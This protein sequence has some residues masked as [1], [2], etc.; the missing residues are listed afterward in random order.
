MRIDIITLFPE[1]F[2]GP[3]ALSIIGRAR[4]RSLVDIG[5]VNPRDFVKDRHRTVDDRPYGG[6]KGM[7]LMAEP[8]YQAIRSVRRKDTKV[9]YLSPKGQTFTQKAARDLSRQKHLALLCGHYEGID[10]RILKYVDMEL[11]IGDYVLTGGEIPAMA[12]TDAVVR[13][14]PDV[15]PEGAV[16][17]ES[18]SRYGLEHPQYTRPRLW[19]G[20]RVPAALVAGD[21]A[22][23]ENWRQAS[24]LKMTMRKRP[25]LLTHSQNH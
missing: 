11:S 14:L 6:G 7:L 15:L 21:H 24:A 5:F 9:I 25:N 19:K 23:I 12:V 20:R 2:D 8:L 3:L 13:L 18:F 10:E 1:M 22:R 16:E 4:E 17:A